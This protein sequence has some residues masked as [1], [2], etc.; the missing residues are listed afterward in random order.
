MRIR[1]LSFITVAAALQLLRVANPHKRA[2]SGAY[3]EVADDR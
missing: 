2:Y 1:V 3:K